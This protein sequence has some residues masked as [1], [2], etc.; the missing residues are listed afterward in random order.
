MIPSNVLTAVLQELDL[1]TFARAEATCSAVRQIAQSVP[2]VGVIAQPPGCPEVVCPV[3]WP[4]ACTTKYV[5][6]IRWLRRHAHQFRC[7]AVFIDE[8]ELASGIGMALANASSL[9][10]LSVRTTACSFTGNWNSVAALTCGGDAVPPLRSLRLGRGTASTDFLQSFGDTLRTLEIAVSS[11]EQAR[12]VFAL[13]M[14]HLEDLDL[15]MG[16]QGTVLLDSAFAM[17]GFPKLRHLSL[18]NMN[19]AGSTTALTL[20]PGG[21]DT[22]HVSRCCFLER[23]GFRGVRVVECLTV[24]GMDFPECLDVSALSALSLSMVPG[25]GVP[26]HV[27]FPKLTRFSAAHTDISLHPSQVPKI[28][29]VVIGSGCHGD[30][31]WLFEASRCFYNN[32]LRM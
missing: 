11:A 27:T 32:N 17:P 25:R 9:H 26:S 30:S 6:F 21:L 8:P 20:P 7:V 15:A 29:T 4:E 28:W 18:G 2:I 10:T 5:C 31:D 16:F 12:G 24:T 19:F 13:D 1:P 23:A 14:P 22:L 3:S